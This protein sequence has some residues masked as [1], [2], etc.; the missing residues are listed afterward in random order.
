[1]G[2]C[3]SDIASRKSN[4]PTEKSV[5]HFDR[6]TYA[7]KDEFYAQH[8]LPGPDYF[9]NPIL[10]G[11]NSDPSICTNGEDYFLVTSS[12]SYYPGVPIFHSRDLVNWTQIGH[13][14]DRP[15]QLPLDGQRVSEGIFAPAISYNPH[16]QTYYMITTNIRRG[17]FFV[18][19]KD[20]FGTWSD[21]I[22][23]PDVHGI[24]PSFFFDDDGKAYIVN[25]DAPDGPALYEG[26][27]AIRVQQFDPE[28]DRT[29]GPR[30]MLV[31][32]GIHPEEKPIWIEGPHLYKIN[33]QYLL[34]AA[35]GG[36]GPDHSEVI[37][38]GD[39]PMGTFVPWNQNPILTQRHLSPDRPN[40][41]TCAGHADL[42]QT[43]EGDWWA[44]FLACRP[45]D[46]NFE[47]LGR[48]TF[49]MPVRWSEDGAPYLTQGEERVPLVVR[50]PGVQRK[51]ATT[52]GNF[53]ATD[54]FD[55]A[56]L[57]QEWFTLRGPATELYSLTENP[58]YLSLRCAD[59][60]A[61]ERNT[62]AFVARRMQ[63]HQFECETTLFFEPADAHDAAGLLLFK[64]ETHQYFLSVRQQNGQKQLALEKIGEAAPELLASDTLADEALLRL[65]VVSRG[66]DYDFY[67]ALGKGGA[68][69]LLC[70]DVP[71]HYLSTANSFG[72]TGTTIAMYATRK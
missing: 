23:L 5:A 39:A 43:P 29:F 10:P 47:N 72:F 63:H 50:R 21:P 4:V 27:R 38:S 70:K 34:M 41:V 58:G 64:D 36:T 1:M 16:N 6:F 33:G 60:S 48:E 51:E 65:K 67:Y 52:F 49:L 30:K 13:V 55:E 18:K 69:T 54:E 2:A 44:V 8:P 35:E 57:G 62:P 26:H 31:N 56:T 59:V 11:W 71:A 12:F 24:D 17:N 32:G 22:W 61:S 7:G 15:E 25:N 42:V 45:L 20:P 66:T 14:L 68:W 46:G 28:T 3:R 19:T 9:Y 53:E 40:P 37:L